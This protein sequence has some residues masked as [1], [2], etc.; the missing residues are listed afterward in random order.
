MPKLA[1]ANESKKLVR[2][3]PGQSQVSDWIEQA[4]NLPR[5]ITY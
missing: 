4:K 3:L 2:K 1:N 5:V